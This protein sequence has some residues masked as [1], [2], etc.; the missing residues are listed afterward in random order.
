MDTSASVVRTHRLNPA[1]W[2]VFLEA[3]ARFVLV[4]CLSTYTCE[5]RDRALQ[6]LTRCE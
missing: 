2:F 1:V 4:G 6:C 5:V 3:V